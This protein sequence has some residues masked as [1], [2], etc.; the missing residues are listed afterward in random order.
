MRKPKIYLETTMFNY[1][2][3]TER[4]AHPATVKLFQEI[5]AGKYEA[6][7][8]AYV[9]DELKNAPEPKRSDMLGLIAKYNI[10][11]LKTETEAEK[12]AEVYVAE[13]IIS[14]KYMYDCVHIACATVNDL[15]YIFS[16]NF[17]HINKIKTK[18]MT[19]AINVREG[20]RTVAIVSPLEVI[21][22]D[23]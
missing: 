18:V 12:L 23:D 15:D 6:Y 16:S 21:G 20:Y 2:F 22:N 7:T 9:V 14:K 4:D 13:G 19:S 5:K 1:Y 10:K 11:M 17:Q 8:S 3:D